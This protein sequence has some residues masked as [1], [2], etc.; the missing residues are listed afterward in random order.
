MNYCCGIIFQEGFIKPKQRFFFSAWIIISYIAI[1]SIQWHYLTAFQT[2]S[3]TGIQWHALLGTSE[4]WM[5]FLALAIIVLIFNL[6]YPKIASLTEQRKRRLIVFF[7]VTANL[8]I[9]GFFN[10][11]NFFIE[12]IEFFLKGLDL[13]PSRFHLNIILPIGVSFYTFKGIS[14]IID[15]YHGKIKNPHSFFDFSLFMAF[16]PSILAGPIDRA[17][18]FLQQICQKRNL[19]WEQSIRGIHLFLSGL[20]KKVVI[21]DGLVRSVASVFDSSG[22]ASWID[23]VSATLLFTVQIYCDFSGY[24]DMARGSAKLFGIDLM[25][26]FRLPYFSK[27]PREF[28]NRWHISLSTWL[29]DYLYIPLGGNRHGQTQTYRNLIMT[30]TLGGLWHGAAWNFVLWGLYH[31][32]ALSIHRLSLRLGRRTNTKVSFTILPKSLPVL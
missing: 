8:V 23:V 29:R 25:V 24:T 30:M 21:A 7:G 27:N 28:W 1:V 9:L 22:Q 11:Y 10:Y 17:S 13:E 14:Y 15:S 19:T 3:T 4:T 31:G 18:S 16:F 26:N 2:T 20:F 32:I 12:N 5:L 6:L